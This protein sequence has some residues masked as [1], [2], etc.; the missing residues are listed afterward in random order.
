MKLFNKQQDEV[1]SLIAVLITAKPYKR[2][3]TDE[4]IIEIRRRLVRKQAEVAESG[5]IWAY[6]L[7]SSY[8]AR[9]DNETQ[10]E[11]FDQLYGVNR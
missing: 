10:R 7:I 5:H 4:K 2:N 6:R 9:L 11:T 1:N 8:I 3:L